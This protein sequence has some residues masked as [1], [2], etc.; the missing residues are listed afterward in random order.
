MLTVSQARWCGGRIF[1]GSRD[2][3]IRCDC[4][5]VTFEKSGGLHLAELDL[6]AGRQSGV[7][8]LGKV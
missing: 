7:Q 4:T 6:T 5:Y 2:S 3:K 8:N 1:S